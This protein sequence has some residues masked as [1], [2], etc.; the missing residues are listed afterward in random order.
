MVLCIIVLRYTDHWPITLYCTVVQLTVWNEQQ[1]SPCTHFSENIMQICAGYLDKTQSFQ[2]NVIAYQLLFSN[3]GGH[4]VWTLITAV[5]WC[6]LTVSCRYWLAMEELA[7][8][9]Y[10]RRPHQRVLVKRIESSGKTLS[11][12][13]SGS[14]RMA[15]ITQNLNM[16]CSRPF[17]KSFMWVTTQKGKLRSFMHPHSR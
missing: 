14:S 17:H 12:V 3:N 16:G 6:T 7:Q 9:L 15:L 11:L 4:I 5:I 1:C 2:W 8:D 13:F 10:C